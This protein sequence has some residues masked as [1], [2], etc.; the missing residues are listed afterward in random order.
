MFLALT[1]VDW[2]TP[3]CGLGSYPSSDRQAWWD[4]EVAW[5]PPM[6]GHRGSDQ[7]F[8]LSGGECDLDNAQMVGTEEE[9]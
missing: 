9:D 2:M 3:I 6:G 7:V 4:I 8:D 1:G 5:G